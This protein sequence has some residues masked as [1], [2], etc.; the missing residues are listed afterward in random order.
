M[1]K[2]EKE[3]K[4]KLIYLILLVNAEYARRK[5]FKNAFEI[6]NFV[7]ENVFWLKELKIIQSIVTFEKCC[8]EHKEGL[9]IVGDNKK[10]EIILRKFD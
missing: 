3:R 4:I 5:P 9:A 8:V 10:T 6:I 7:T 1:T 2:Q